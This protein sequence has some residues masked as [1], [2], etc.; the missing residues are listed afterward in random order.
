M[1]GF[2]TTNAVNLCEIYL[3]KRL[4]FIEPIHVSPPNL[5]EP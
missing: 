4:F 3:V 2:N 5:V 1:L